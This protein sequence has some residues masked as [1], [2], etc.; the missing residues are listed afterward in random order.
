MV[1][2]EVACFFVVELE[3]FSIYSCDPLIFAVLSSLILL[4][5][6]IPAKSFCI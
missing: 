5:R 1:N 6:D 4:K 2:A 3:A